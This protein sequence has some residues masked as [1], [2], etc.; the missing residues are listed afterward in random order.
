MKKVSLFVDKTVKD[1]LKKN[2]EWSIAYRAA[3]NFFAKFVAFG[4]DPQGRV[5][6]QNLRLYPHD[7][8]DKFVCGCHS[9]SGDTQRA[10]AE[11]HRVEV[12]LTLRWHRALTLEVSAYRTGVKEPYHILEF[13]FAQDGSEATAHQSIRSIR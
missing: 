12:C 11:A 9:E 5:V 1:A 8:L 6:V 2:T 4:T 3:L 10:F 7:G 13:S